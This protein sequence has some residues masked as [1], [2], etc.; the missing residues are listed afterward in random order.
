MGA[1]RRLALF[2]GARLR[3]RELSREPGGFRPLGAGQ[4]RAGFG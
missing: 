4:G 1:P 2:K 3:E